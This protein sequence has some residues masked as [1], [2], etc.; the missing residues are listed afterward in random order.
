MNSHKSLS[1]AWSE[2]QVTTTRDGS[3][4][5][6]TLTGSPGEYALGQGIA[7][8]IDQWAAIVAE[9][10]R[11][12]FDAVVVSPGKSFTVHV[13]RAIPIDWPPEGRK[14]RHVSSLHDQGTIE[15]PGGLD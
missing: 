10:A 11:E 3:A 9:R 4:V 14:V 7:G 2:Q 5:T 13:T 15:K 8:G 6:R 12:A 1:R